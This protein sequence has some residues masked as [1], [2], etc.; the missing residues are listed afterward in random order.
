MGAQA[1]VFDRDQRLLLVRHAYQPGW[2][3]P[4]GGVESGETVVEALARELAEEVGL[5]LSKPPQ[6]VGIYANFAAFPGDHIALFEVRDW[7]QG[8]V[9]VPSREI[10]EQAFFAGDALP[11]DATGGTRRRIAEFLGGAQKSGTW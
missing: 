2:H 1:M 5:T 10:E 6:L 4:G 8:Q 3:F 7:E 9:P 11:S